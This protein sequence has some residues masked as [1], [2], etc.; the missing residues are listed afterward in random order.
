MCRTV[1]SSHLRKIN[2]VVH[3]AVTAWSFEN[4]VV[5]FFV[6]IDKNN[7]TSLL[8]WINNRS[9]TMSD[10]VQ[11][12]LHYDTRSY[13]RCTFGMKDTRVR[14]ALEVRQHYLIR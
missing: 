5:I 1:I 6:E 3:L 4:A 11:Q 8:S 12:G 13:R 2:I 14:C 9:F 7:N 10:V